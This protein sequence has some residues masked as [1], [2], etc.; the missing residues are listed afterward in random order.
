VDFNWRTGSPAA[1]IG[2][3]TFS[4]RWEGY[5]TAVEGGAY[6]FRTVSDDGVRLWVNGQL[7]IDDWSGDGRR[8]NT[9]GA[10]NL[11]AGQTVSIRMEYFENTGR[12]L[13]S[14]QWRRPGQS[15]FGVIPREQLTTDTTAGQTL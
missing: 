4:I 3:D 2:A 13:A 8:S 7:V 14:L 10:I 5:V 12:A 9:T 1:G 11:A 6:R 15:S